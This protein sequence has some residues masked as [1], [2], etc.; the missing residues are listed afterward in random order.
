[1]AT[2]RIKSLSLARYV[3]AAL[4]AAEYERDEGDVVIGNV[5]SVSGFFAQGETYEEARS[6]LREVIEGNV[7][8]ALQLGWDVPPVP[9]V[10][11]EEQDVEA[12]APQA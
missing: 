10:D 3:S 8:V 6:N 5:P 2:S 9:G 12:N 4:E 1:M 7:L 11:I